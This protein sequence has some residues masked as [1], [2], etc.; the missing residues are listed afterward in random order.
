MI[1]GAMM[2]GMNKSLVRTYYLLEECEKHLK[3]TKSSGSV[4]ESYLTQHAL[5]VFCSEMQNRIYQLLDE[6]AGSVLD[7]GV[8]NYI[9][10]SGRRLSRSVQKAEIANIVGLF[11]SDAKDKFNSALDDRD[12][13]LYN[14]AVRD[15]HDVAHSY[16]AN[17]TFSEVKGAVSIAEKILLAFQEAIQPIST[18]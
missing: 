15:R 17:V 16:G 7:G 14:N 3:S 13:T 18:E 6:R 2:G 12:V 5:V 9:S 1:S 11:G 4:I 10:S 8:R